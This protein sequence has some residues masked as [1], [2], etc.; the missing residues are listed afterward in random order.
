VIAFAYP[1]SLVV[2]GAD[3]GPFSEHSSYKPF[4]QS[5]F[6]RRCIYCRKPD[7]TGEEGFGVDHYKPKVL[8][9]SR[10]DANAWSNLFYACNPC[11]R[12]KEDYWPTARERRAAAYFPNP[13]ADVMLSHL[14]FT[15]ATVVAI[16]PCGRF[17]EEAL[18]L[19]DEGLVKLRETLILALA[20]ALEQRRK[21]NLALSHAQLEADIQLLQREVERLDDLV[22]ALA[23]Q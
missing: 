22:S 19:N 10:R 11:N 21:V 9:D 15:G 18:E 2:R 20:Q 17:V 8:F 14:R 16:S 5:L 1:K 12:R 3:P 4:L 23:E 7:I 6:R 13:C